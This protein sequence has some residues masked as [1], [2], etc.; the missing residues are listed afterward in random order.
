VCSGSTTS[1]RIGPTFVASRRSAGA[2]RDDSTD[3][4]TPSRTTLNAASATKR[5]G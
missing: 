5:F 1:T 4:C 2:R 3:D